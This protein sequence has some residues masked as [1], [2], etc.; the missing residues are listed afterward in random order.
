MKKIKFIP[1]LF[2]IILSK[3][4]LG[5][6]TFTA[7][8]TG[9][10]NTAFGNPGSPWSVSGS[11]TDGI[12]DGDDDVVINADVSLPA[13]NCNAGSIVIGA[14]GNLI[15]NSQSYKLFI[16]QPSSVITNNGE[17]SGSGIIEIRQNGCTVS[18]SGVWTTNIYFRINRNTTFDNVNITFDS[19]FL[20]RIGGSATINSNSTLT[21]NSKVFSSSSA[22]KLYNYGTI[23]FN[24]NDVFRPPYEEAQTALINYSGSTVNYGASSGTSGD[25]PIPNNGYYNLNISGIAD[26]NGDLTIYEN[27]TNNGTFTSSLAGNTVT[28][29]G[30]SSQNILGSGTNNFKNLVLNN[31]NGL[32][33]NGGTI[34]IEE[35]LSSTS[36]SI[37]QNGANVTLVSTSDNNAGAIKI[38]SSSDYSY[39]SGDFTANRYYNGTSD[40]WRMVAAPIK[41]ATLSDWDDEFIYCGI[42]G[43]TGNY[44]LCELW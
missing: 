37:T 11:D 5:Q 25:F 33:L 8:S 36:G 3:S 6:A 27:W 9:D 4:I 20:I 23:N 22:S 39:V 44:S 2:L 14:A 12:P 31:I 21:F 34:N 24:S 7:N 18:G 10:W 1:F 42:T 41:S 30:S 35:I 40:G 15:L 43:G 26:C 17:I 29:N 13:S 19:F 32:N 16:D 38:N 28:F